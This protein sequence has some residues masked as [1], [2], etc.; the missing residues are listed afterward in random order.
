M[1]ALIS[2]LRLCCLG[3][4]PTKRDGREQREGASGQCSG[5]PVLVVILMVI[6]MLVMVVIMVMVVMVV[7]VIMVVMVAR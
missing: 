2:L 3:G 7:M 6:M 1:K 5:E 4:A